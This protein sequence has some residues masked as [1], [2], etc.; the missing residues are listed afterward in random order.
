MDAEQRRYEELERQLLQANQ[1]I[2]QERQRADREQRLKEQETQ[3]ADREQRLKEQEHQLRL[4]AEHRANEA[5]NIA[6]VKL[7]CYW[8]QVYQSKHLTSCAAE[9][10]LSSRIGP[11]V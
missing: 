11:L 5:L 1:I 2:N 6:Y 3:R 10:K 7:L 4:Q 8:R 9:S